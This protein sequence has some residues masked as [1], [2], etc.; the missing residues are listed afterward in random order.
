M[1]RRVASLLPS[2]TEIVAA[3]GGLDQLVGRS[4]ECDFPPEV[5]ELPVISRPRR[6]PVGPSAAIHRDVQQLLTEVLSIYQV[7]VDALTAAAPDL[8]LTQDLCRVCAV[9]EDEVVAAAKAHLGHTVEVLTSSPLTLDA[10][11]DDVHRVAVALG[12][13]PAGVALV[14]ALRGEL[15][16][17]H[18]AVADRPRPTLVLLEWVDPLMAGGTW[19]PE[20]IE[21]AGATPLLGVRGGHSPILTFDEL[22]AADPDILVLSPCGYDLERAGADVPLLTGQ[23]GWA[24]LRAA[25]SGRVAVIDGSAYVN[26]PG[27]R[28]VETTAILAAIAHG[29]GPGRALEG[30]GWRWVD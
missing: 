7:D 20:L 25:R 27:P 22:R 2:T 26:R 12:D 11:L 9:A 24:E 10:V 18:A 16:T 19:G 3:L 5:T 17:I 28:L 6:E 30:A 21:T 15:D 1:R 23:P 13:A 8:I 14:A 29:V 4:H